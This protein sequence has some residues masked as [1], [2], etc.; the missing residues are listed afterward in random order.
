M[1]K[2]DGLWITGSEGRLGSELVHLFKKNS[3][4]KIVATDRDI[5]ITDLDQVN[6]AADIYDVSIVINCA[7]I[8]DREYC[9]ENRL[10][11]YRV[12][13]LGARN[14]AVATRRKNGTII[15]I[16]TDDVF[17]GI[18]NRSKNEFDVP[19]PVTEFGKSKLAGE[20]LVREMNPKHLIVRSSWVY[21][22]R[23]A[24]LEE[25]GD[26]YQSVLKHGEKGESFECPIDVIS[27][28]TSTLEI[29]RFL[30]KAVSA[31]EYG[32]FH[33]SC[34][35]ACTRREYAKAILSLHGYDPEL[36]KASF[37]KKNGAVTS[38]LLENLMLNMTGIHQMKDW[39]EALK[40]YVE[41]EKGEKS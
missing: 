11:A 1:M 14:L 16:S 12:N 38:T 9:E 4:F 15:H 37:E 35:G 28:P 40:E 8:S 25:Y 17:S 41:R 26:F 10:D 39:H 24:K 33:V 36:C 2:R 27:S 19:T 34:E 20:M 21:G 32:I 29:A 22:S 5:D 30:K 23:K 3:D 31:N 13:A 18:N 6:R 7:S